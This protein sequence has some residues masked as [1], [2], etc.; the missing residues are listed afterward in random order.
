[1]LYMAQLYPEMAKYY[2]GHALKEL[3]RLLLYDWTDK[4]NKLRHYTRG[5][6][7]GM[8]RYKA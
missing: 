2:R 7:E 4:H 8:K 6:V 5:L 1:M 3:K